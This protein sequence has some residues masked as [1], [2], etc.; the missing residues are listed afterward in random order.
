[1][2]KTKVK[3]KALVYPLPAVLAGALVDK[4]V[5]YNT[6]G[7]CGIV[8]IDPPV[9]Y[10][11]SEKKHHTNTGIRDTGYFSV[12]IPSTDLMEKTDYCGVVTGKNTDKSDVFNNFYGKE[13]LAPMIKECPVNLLCKVMEVVDVYGM[14]VFIGE[15]IETYVSTDCL[16][17]GKADTKKIDPLVYTLDN[18]YWG[19]GNIAGKGFFAGVEYK[20]KSKCT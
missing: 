18:N 3:N 10:I 6:L 16:T 4:K 12:N 2:E 20:K 7:N 14:E 11:S 1:M 5:N 8:N 15:V 17:D 13:K 19:L 9:I